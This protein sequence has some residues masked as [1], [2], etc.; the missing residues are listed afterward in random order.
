MQ[1]T[2]VGKYIDEKSIIRSS[3][4]ALADDSRNR[5]AEKLLRDRINCEIPRRMPHVAYLLQT[6]PEE[7]RP[8]ESTTKLC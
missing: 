3:R 8:R 2:V 1:G 7:D 6:P 4:K 5:V